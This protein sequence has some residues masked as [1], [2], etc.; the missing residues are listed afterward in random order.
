MATVT[1]GKK[2][3]TSTSER[4]QSS[5]ASQS[6]QGNSSFGDGFARLFGTPWRTFGFGW[7]APLFPLTPDCAPSTALPG[8]QLLTRVFTFVLNII[9]ARSLSLANYGVSAVQFHLINS[10][11]VFLAREGVRRS[12]L[13]SSSDDASLIA[14]SLV[15]IPAGIVLS[16][17][18]G[19]FF[20]SRGNTAAVMQCVAAFVEVLSEPMYILS[21]SRNWFG[22][23]TG[24][25][26]VAMVVKNL[27]SVWLLNS[28]AFAWMDP[29][30]AMSWGQVVYGGMLFACLAVGTWIMTLG[31]SVSGG[32][33]N[34]SAHTSSSSWMAGMIRYVGSIR[35]AFFSFY[36]TFTLQAIGKLVL[37]EGSKAVLAVVTSPEVQ[38]V[39]GLV[40]NLGSLVVRTLF[41]PFEELVFVT[42]SGGGQDDDLKSDKKRQ[43]MLLSSLSQLVCVVGGIMATFG[44]SYSYVALRILYGERWA[45]SDAPRALGLYSIYVAL[46][47]MNGTL[48]AFLHGVADQKNLLKNNVAL[49]LASLAHMGLSVAAVRT[50]G[51]A[52]LLA[53]DGINMMLRIAYSCIFV[54]GYFKEV[55][56]GWRGVGLAPS[57]RIISALA[58]ASALSRASEAVFLRGEATLARIARHVGTGAILLLAVIAVVYSDIRRGK[59]SASAVLGRRKAKQM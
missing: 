36:A 38:G 23:R 43:A 22:M 18:A 41:Q 28:A 39:Y 31:G 15:A 46:L 11:I 51:A 20:H 57:L 59:L 13:R 48:E 4:S 34:V 45:S 16:S 58:L 9:I 2:G 50:H 3:A 53:A 54:N 56:G 40:N 27:V 7:H 10:S 14:G 49:I 12:C 44:P 17:A 6:S 33:G 55:C 19:F 52:G 37:A 8:S 25:E 30:V 1:K 21:T 29:T 24:C 26:A 5:H 35:P 47:A 32:S 42:F